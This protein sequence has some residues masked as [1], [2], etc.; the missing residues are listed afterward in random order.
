[1]IVSFRNV[2]VQEQNVE[3]YIYGKKQK[4][5]QRTTETER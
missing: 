3:T 1:M 2:L 4:K 5:K